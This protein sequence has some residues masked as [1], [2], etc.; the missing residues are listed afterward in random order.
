MCVVRIMSAISS[1]PDHGKSSTYDHAIP[2]TKNDRFASHARVRIRC[3]WAADH[4]PPRGAGMSRS[5]SFRMRSPAAIKHLHFSAH[6]R[7]VAGPSLSLFALSPRIFA[8]ARFPLRA[9]FGNALPLSPPSRTPR[10]LA[11]ARAAFVR[12]EIILASCS[13]T[14]GEDMNC[15]PICG[16]EIASGELNS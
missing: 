1:N 12:S 3:T 9:T 4:G 13:A 15:Q 7:R 16:R 14:A 6:L 5:F 8:L 11:A 10:A 2:R